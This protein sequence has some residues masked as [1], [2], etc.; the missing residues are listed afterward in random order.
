MDKF[1]TLT[2]VAAPIPRVNVD[3]D[4]IIPKQ[5]LKTIQRHRPRQ[6][7]LL[8]MALQDDGSETPTSS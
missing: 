5:Y 7:P 1:T 4:A 6:G 2:A 3:T 8:R